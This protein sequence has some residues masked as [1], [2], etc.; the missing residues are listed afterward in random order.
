MKFL[1]ILFFT[2][3]TIINAQELNCKVRVNVESLETYY[4]DFLDDFASNV[5]DYLNKTKYYHGEWEGNRIECSMDIFFTSASNEVNYAAQVVITSQREIY[6]SQNYTRMLTVSDNNWTFRYEE[7][8]SFYQNETSFDPLTSF[9]DFYANV[10]IGFDLDSYAELGG[11]PYF[12]KALNIVNFAATGGASS[13]WLNTTSSY[14]RRKLVQE[15]LD[16]RYRPVREGFYDYFY[17]IDYYSISKKEAQRLIVKFID[18]VYTAK[19]K[20]EVRSVLMKTFFDTKFGE[21]IEKLKGY[22]DEKGILIKLKK[23]DPSHAAK[24]DE[25]IEI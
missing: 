6:K 7:G 22:Q 11:S 10:L 14:S 5:E 24:Y 23:I 19:D 17:G 13:S 18:R 20:L 21:I 25:A 12:T 9:L 15:L 16:E 1:L 8:Q 4:R 3:S 2:L